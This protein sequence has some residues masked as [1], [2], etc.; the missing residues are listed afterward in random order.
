[1]VVVLAW[2]GTASAQPSSVRH[3]TP[4]TGGYDAAI[5]IDAATGRVLIEDNPAVRNPPASMTKLMTFAVV[6]GSL[7]AGTLTLQTPVKI[8]AADARLG[9][10][11]VYLDPRE[12]LTVEELLYA[13]MVQ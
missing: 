11:Q 6:H 8:E 3:A 13:L 10:T 1:N 4:V 7:T 9:G 2:G 5:V 12:T